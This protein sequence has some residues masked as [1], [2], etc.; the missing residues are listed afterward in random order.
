[1]NDDYQPT[2]L[3]KL[4]DLME[5]SDKFSRYKELHG[6]DGGAMINCLEELTF[7]TPEVLKETVTKSLGQVRYFEDPNLV[8]NKHMECS[9]I[10]LPFDGTEHDSHKTLRIFENDQ[11]RFICIEDTEVEPSAGGTCPWGDVA[12]YLNPRKEK[13]E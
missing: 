9:C 7:Y 12:L 11:Y 2:P 10:S 5:R 6:E 4:I 8:P 13:E 1:M 3:G